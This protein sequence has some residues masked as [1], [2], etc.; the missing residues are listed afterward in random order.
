M[1]RRKI[2]IFCYALYVDAAHAAT[3]KMMSRLTRYTPEMLLLRYDGAV[4]R[5]AHTAVR[6]RVDPPSFAVISFSL[7]LTANILHADDMP[8]FTMESGSRNRNEG[9]RGGARVMS[10]NARC[11]VDESCGARGNA[12]ARRVDGAR[13]FLLPRPPRPATSHCTFIE[14]ARR[15]LCLLRKRGCW[16][17]FMLATYKSDS[18]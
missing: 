11:A 17:Y 10:R 13:A 1:S 7:M 4:L 16:R 5:Y 15:S 12:Q 14:T 18:R 6:P 9:G 8:E 2:L 3:Q